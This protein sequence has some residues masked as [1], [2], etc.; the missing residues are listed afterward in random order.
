[1]C[2]YDIVAGAMFEDRT[3]QFEKFGIP[4]DESEAVRAK[5]A[6][7]GA[8]NRRVAGCTFAEER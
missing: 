6:R 1:M 3:H 2:T 8:E 7:G 4:L 5:G